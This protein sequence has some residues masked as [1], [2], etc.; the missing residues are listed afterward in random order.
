MLTLLPPFFLW[1][2]H[3]SYSDYWKDPDFVALRVTSLQ[4]WLDDILELQ[5]LSYPGIKAAFETFVQV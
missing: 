4:Q 2:H 1:C 3:V 5:S